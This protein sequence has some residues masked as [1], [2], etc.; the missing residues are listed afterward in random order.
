[1]QAATSLGQNI[2][3]NIKGSIPISSTQQ[4]VPGTS[5][6][7][8]GQAL[9]Y[10]GIQEKSPSLGLQQQPL[11]GQQFQQ[12]LPAQQFQQNLPGQQQ[13]S[14]LGQQNL[15]GQ[16]FA[17][18]Q[19]QQFSNLQGGYQQGLQ[20][21]QFQPMQQG[22]MLQGGQQFLDQQ[23]L[24]SQQFLGQQQ[25]LES[26]KFLGQQQGFQQWLPQQQQVISQQ[27][28]PATQVQ[29]APA[30]LEHRECAP[31]IQ[32]RIR[33]E[34]V[35]EI[36]PVIHREREKT[37]IHKITQPVH[38]SAVLGVV[39]EE[40]TLPAKFTEIRT[41][42]MLPPVS[43]LPK[44]E[45]LSAQK[46]RVQTAPVVIETEKKKIIEE[47]T[48]VVHR[49]VV[50]PHLTKLTLPIYE[51]IVEG[52]VYVSEIRPAQV[53]AVE[54]FAAPIQTTQLV[55]QNV[56]VQI[57]IQSQIPIF[58]KNVAVAETYVK[59]GIPI[60]TTANRGLFGRKAV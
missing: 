48:P 13:F 19:D 46:M 11:Q 14:N 23:N 43:I 29:V 36:H 35:E 41:P 32:E 15:Q 8:T 33:K 22:Q 58:T 3:D 38:T 5:S 56:P 2:A 12:N 17:N 7:S 40:A 57:P 24:Q 37:E 4:T 39:T 45:E 55:Q 16:Q 10:S 52:D 49:E 42:S 20:G 47:V 53:M 21:Q 28:L 44:R 59:E 25:G 60:T 9:P 26:Q 31:V 51:K 50:E 27:L 1:M 54:S 34:E 30:I 18:L 6:L